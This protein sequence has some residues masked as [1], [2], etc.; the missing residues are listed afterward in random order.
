MA[1]F[2]FEWYYERAQLHPWNGIW[3]GIQSGSNY[4]IINRASG[5]A[6]EVP[7]GA[8]TNALQLQQYTDN[9]A[10]AQ[11]WVISDQG[12][13]NNYYKLQSVSSPDSKVMDVRN[14]TKNNG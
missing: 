5:K 8:N 11:Q 6:L 4:K 14:G 1:R 10:A 2:I 13:Y 9:G 7:G 3:N 12:T